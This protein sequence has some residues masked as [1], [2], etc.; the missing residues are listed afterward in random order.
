M[1]DRSLESLSLPLEVRA[2]LAELE[3]ELSEGKEG[4]NKP[5]RQ[6]ARQPASSRS[7]QA[8]REDAAA[9]ATATASS[10]SFS[11]FGAHRSGSSPAGQKEGD[12]GEDEETQGPSP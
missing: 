11:P 6:P 4:R 1:A 3:L 5:A 9:T 12:G 2:R 7:A 8:I 10:S